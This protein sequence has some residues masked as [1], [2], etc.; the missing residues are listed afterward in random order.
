MDP[1]YFSVLA[2]FFGGGDVSAVMAIGWPRWPVHLFAGL[3]LIANI[4]LVHTLRRES[5]EHPQ[6]YLPDSLQDQHRL[7]EQ[8]RTIR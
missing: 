7:A 6:R 2:P 4:R 1:L 3:V 5:K 8:P